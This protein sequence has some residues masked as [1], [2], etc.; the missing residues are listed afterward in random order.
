MVRMV[1]KEEKKITLKFLSQLE[2]LQKEYLEEERKIEKLKKELDKLEA[3]GTVKDTVSGGMGGTQHFVVEGF[4]VAAYSRKKTNLYRR[5]MNAE[6]L[7]ER[8]ESDILTIEE[9]VAKIDDSCIRRIFDMRVIGKMKWDDIA[10][11]IGGGNT[12]DDVRKKF[13]RFIE[14]MNDEK[15]A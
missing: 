2:H 3:E 1:K 12:A 15:E 14:R 9:F 7:Q 13:T 4:P 8:I 10:D 5:I 6:A 11:T